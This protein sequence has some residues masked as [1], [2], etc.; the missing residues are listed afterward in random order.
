MYIGMNSG[1]TGLDVHSKH[2][3]LRPSL[4]WPEVF[5]VFW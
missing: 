2:I 3:Q 1:K 5:V 4:D